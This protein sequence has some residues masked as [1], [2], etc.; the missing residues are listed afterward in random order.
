MF[1]GIQTPA[2]LVGAGVLQPLTILQGQAPRFP[3]NST[4]LPVF[5]A[6]RQSFPSGNLAPLSAAQLNRE[7]RLHFYSPRKHSFGPRGKSVERHG[8]CTKLLFWVSA[9]PLPDL[10]Q[11]ISIFRALASHLPRSLLRLFTRERRGRVF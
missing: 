4:L 9:L 2:S 7:A 10:E 5:F 1:R 6:T 3:A 8:V 11:A